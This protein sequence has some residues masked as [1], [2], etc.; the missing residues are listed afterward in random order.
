LKAFCFV[1]FSIDRYRLDVP[2]RYFL[3]LEIHYTSP[4]L[5]LWIKDVADKRQTNIWEKHKSWYDSKRNHL[6][7]KIKVGREI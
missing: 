5:S 2:Y 7:R 1:A 4:L 3:G 6:N